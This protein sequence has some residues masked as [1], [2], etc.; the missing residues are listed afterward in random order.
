MGTTV[1]ATVLAVVVTALGMLAVA[2]VMNGS[3]RPGDPMTALAWFYPVMAVMAALM[4]SIGVLAGRVPGAA[5]IVLLVAAPLLVT[6]LPTGALAVAGR[7]PSS[8]AAAAVDMSGTYVPFLIAGALL[9]HVLDARIRVGSGVLAVVA[10]IAGAALAVWLSGEA[11]RYLSQASL[12]PGGDT[13]PGAG[14]MLAATAVVALTSAAARG[15]PLVGLVAAGTLVLGWAAA[16]LALSQVLSAVGDDRLVVGVVTT[17]CSQVWFT[18]AGIL[19]LPQVGAGSE[20]DT[21]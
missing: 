8:L 3:P 17:L 4:L 14:L 20:P 15:R 10:G 21:G 13:L 18:V 5:T 12:G 7:V 2:V 11:L 9:P 6:A 16:A 19:A 1:A